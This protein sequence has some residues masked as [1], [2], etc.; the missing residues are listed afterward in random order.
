MRICIYAAASDR[1]D[2]RYMRAV[3][4]IG[5]KLEELLFEEWRIIK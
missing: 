4:N 3:E 1:I 5:E 2:P